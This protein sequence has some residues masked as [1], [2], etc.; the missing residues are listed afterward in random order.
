ME[1]CTNEALEEIRNSLV[2]ITAD[3]TKRVTDVTKR[4]DLAISNI[5]DELSEVKQLLKNFQ[6]GSG[7]RGIDI[8]P[9]VPRLIKLGLPRFTGEDPQGWLYQAEEYFAFHSI[10]EGA[11]IHIEALHMSK[12]AL[13]WIRGLRRNNLIST[14]AKFTED[15]SERFGGS[16]FDDKLEELSR[17]Q[18]TGTV[19]AYMAQFENL[20]NEV[21]GQT[22]EALITFFI[23]GL[24][25]EIKNQLKIMRPTS[26][27]K[28]LE[29]TKVYKANK[30]SKTWKNFPPINRSEPILKTPPAG[31]PAVPIVRRTLTNE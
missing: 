18:Q 31:G 28:A 6:E 21:E 10:G 20:L 2:T 23:G 24:K 1:G 15:L 22:K 25:L 17:L 14:W 5:C 7:S 3:Q 4:H 27:W 13:V 11:K 19:A 30:R 12:D 29:T 16:A 9:K 26:L 8:D